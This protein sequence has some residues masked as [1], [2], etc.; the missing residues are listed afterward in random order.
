M[1]IFRD[2]EELCYNTNVSRAADLIPRARNALE[3]ERLN[4]QGSHG[5][6]RRL[7]TERWHEQKYIQ[8]LIPSG[9]RKW[10]LAVLVKMLFL[11]YDRTSVKAC[12]FELSH[13]GLI[14]VTPLYLACGKFCLFS[15][16]SST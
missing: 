6:H 4:L 2:V 9:S 12:I 15:L 14:G 7:L 1:G 8:S 3:A 11:T 5:S 10:I 13:S 16:K